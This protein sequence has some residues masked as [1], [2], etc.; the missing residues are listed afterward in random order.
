MGWQFT[1][2]NVNHPL[3]RLIWWDSVTVST[4]AI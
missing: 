2:T 4:G 1:L 3:G